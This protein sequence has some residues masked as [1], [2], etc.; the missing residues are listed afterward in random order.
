MLLADGRIVARG[1]PAE[2]RDG[3][4]DALTGLFEAAPGGAVTEDGV[5]P[6]VGAAARQTEGEESGGERD[7]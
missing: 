7:E 1:P 3:D 6:M 4:R 2:F 5:A